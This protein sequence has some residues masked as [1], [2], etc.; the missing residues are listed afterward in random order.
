MP[1]DGTEGQQMMDN[2][3]VDDRGNVLLQEDP[4]GNTTSRR[5]GATTPTATR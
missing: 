1:L 2:I 4:G 3:T 5:S